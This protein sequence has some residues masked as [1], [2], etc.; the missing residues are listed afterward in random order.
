MAASTSRVNEDGRISNEMNT[1][2]EAGIADAVL[3]Q[4]LHIFPHIRLRVTGTCMTPDLQPGDTVGIVSR[5]RREPKWGDIVLVRH[6][7]GLRLHRLVWRWPFATDRSRWLTKADRRMECDPRVSPANLLGTVVRIE[8][9]SH[10]RQLGNGW[11][12]K[13]VLSLMAGLI[14]WARARLLSRRNVA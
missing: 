3:Q 13:T 5:S 7:D 10:T 4:C 14:A 8:N 12:R 11:F 9:D 6:Q 2:W 1:G